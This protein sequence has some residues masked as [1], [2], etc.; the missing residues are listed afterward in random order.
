[1][2]LQTGGIPLADDQHELAL[3]VAP[4]A[5]AVRLGRLGERVAGDRRRPDGAGREQLF[6]A[7]EM[8][9]V[10]RDARAQ[11]LDIDR[12]GGVNPGPVGNVPASADNFLLRAMPALQRDQRKL[13]PLLRT[14]RYFRHPCG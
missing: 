14:H 7:F 2:T 6:H 13:G 1:M 9:A 4:F 12:F 11:H 10:A 5:D 3:E 8:R